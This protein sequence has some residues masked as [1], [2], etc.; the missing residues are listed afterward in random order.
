MYNMGRGFSTIV[1]NHNIDMDII[2]DQLDKGKLQEEELSR[3]YTSPVYQYTK[4]ECGGRDHE[5]QNVRRARKAA[6]IRGEV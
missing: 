2:F 1:H 5:L 6:N 4:A 3:F